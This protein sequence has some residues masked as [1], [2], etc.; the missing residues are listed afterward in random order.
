MLLKDKAKKWLSPIFEEL[1]NA[2]ALNLYLVLFG[3]DG[4]DNDLI[5]PKPAA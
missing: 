4:C 1:F 3:Q 5:Q 2:Q